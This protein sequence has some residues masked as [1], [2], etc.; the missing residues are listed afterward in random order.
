MK[1]TLEIDCDNAAFEDYGLHAE[2]T[3]IL[4]DVSERIPGQPEACDML[5]HDINGNYCGKFRLDPA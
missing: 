2:L 4:A 3:R 5:I 1:F